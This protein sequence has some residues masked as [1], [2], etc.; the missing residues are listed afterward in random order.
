M[1][2]LLVDTRADGLDIRPIDP[3]GHRTSLPN[4]VFFDDVKVAGR[5]VIGNVGE[6]WQLLMP[7][8]NLERLLLAA[9]SA[10]QCLK[11]IE[12]ARDWANEREA[13]GEKI[14]EF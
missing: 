8:L 11:I 1:S 10:G 12:L 13:F 3:L 4:E 6:G 14:T 7:G 5:E 2:L 9:A